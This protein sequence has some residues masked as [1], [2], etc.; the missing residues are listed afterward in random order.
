MTN[1][2]AMRPLLLPFIFLLLPLLTTAQESFAPP[3]AEWCARV[4]DGADETRGYIATKYVRDTVVFGRKMQLFSARGRFFDE[5]G[6][7][8]ES[9][10]RTQVFYQRSDS[11]FYY[12]PVLR[13]GQFIYRTS[14]TV[15]DTTQTALT[16]YP[17]LVTSAEPRRIGHR[18]LDVTEMNVFGNVPVDIP[19]TM[20]GPIGPDRGFFATWAS[21]VRGEGGE[22][23]QSFRADTVAELSFLARNNQCFRLMDAPLARPRVVSSPDD[24]VPVVYPQPASTAGVPLQLDLPC[25]LPATA[26][27]QLLIYDASGRRVR[28]MK[29]VSGF[30]VRLETVGLPSGQY[31]VVLEG[32]DRKYT[33]PLQVN[34]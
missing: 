17:L 26:T 22:V 2:S 34:H 8:A 27:F 11:V 32:T 30:P 12:N 5:V 23:L 7:L 14:Y 3:G 29:D 31:F 4:F 6:N 10:L 16:G 28:L 1:F 25:G 18:L 21:A 15:G 24:C 9:Q 19:V 20:Y 33:V 13:A